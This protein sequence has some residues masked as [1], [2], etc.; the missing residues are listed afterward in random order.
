MKTLAFFN[1]KGGVGKTSLVQH[2]SWMFAELGV[3]VVAI[4][5]DP[6][7][8]LTSSFLEDETLIEL[9]GAGQSS[10]T[11]LGLIQ[12][13]LD[14]LG[15]IKPPEVTAVDSRIGL[16]PGDLGLSLFEDRLAETWG[17]CFDDN[18]ANAADAFRVTTAFYRIMEQA[19]RQNE[20]QIVLIDVGPN[21]GAIN[22]AA[23]ISADH[24]VIPLAADL[25]S[26][27]G[28]RNLGPT[29][30]DWRY[31]WEERKK[32]A[33]NLPSLNLRI[34]SGEMDPAGYVVMQPSVR[35]NYP[36]AA[37]RK[38]IARIPE[39]Y[40]LEV[41]G[42]P[43]FEGA[44]NSDPMALATLKNYRSLAPMAQESRKPI[45]ALKPA[46]GAIGG[47]AAAVQDCHRAFRQL[48]E[49]IAK[50]CGFSLPSKRT[51]KSREIIT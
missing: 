43:A 51:G 9:W 34:P 44:P 1:N 32:R 35:E 6:Q 39:V 19:A 42:R 24:V 30:R 33:R 13:L 41:L 14:R 23:L 29:L 50:A 27:Q 22:R 38:W 37:Y 3:N 12:P 15:D 2:L 26:L 25:F 47:H 17:R 46:D 18:P 36:V 10:R 31:G 20:A 40:Y 45:F 49:R 28:L 5:L 8:N 4:D 21:L 16:I 7:S 48:A 11:I